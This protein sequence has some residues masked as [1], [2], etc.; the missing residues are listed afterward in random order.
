MK[1]R[2]PEIEHAAD[3]LVKRIQDHVGLALWDA[4]DA[5]RSAKGAV[6]DCREDIADA[7]QEAAERRVR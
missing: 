5:V 7:L 4:P 3:A 1:Y 2:S 6:R